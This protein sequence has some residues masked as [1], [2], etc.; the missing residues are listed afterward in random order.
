MRATGFLVT[1]TVVTESSPFL[2]SKEEGGGTASVFPCVKREARMGSIL[3]WK[4]RVRHHIPGEY[5]R[6]QA[7]IALGQALQQL[8]NLTASRS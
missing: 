6:V 4:T 5:L 7:R 1:A 3:I 2:D 8:H